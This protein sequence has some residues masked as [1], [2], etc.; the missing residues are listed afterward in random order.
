MGKWGN[1]TNCDD[2]GCKLPCRSARML[3]VFHVLLVSKIE[4]VRE[5]VLECVRHPVRDEACH[6]PLPSMPRNRVKIFVR[7]VKHQSVKKFHRRASPSQTRTYHRELPSA[8]VLVGCSTLSVQCGFSING[9]LK[10]TV[11]TTKCGEGC[12]DMRTLYP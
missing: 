5:D 12:K 11:P 8:K 9:I 3:L 2:A 1:N 7:P 4:K 10:P 6:T